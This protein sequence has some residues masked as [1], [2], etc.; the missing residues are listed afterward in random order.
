RFLHSS[1]PRMRSPAKRNES[2]GRRL[3][4]LWD[5]LARRDRVPVG[6]MMRLHS[7]LPDASQVPPPADG[8]VPALVLNVGRL[9]LH[10]RGVG[11]IRSLGRMGVPAYATVENRWPPAAVSRY[12]A[13]AFV[14]DT[15]RLDTARFLAGMQ[16]IGKQ[17]DRPTV[18]IPTGDDAAIL[19]AEHADEL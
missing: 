13:G 2:P 19:I 14:W 4:H 16:L 11:I 10:H 17:L 3:P 8:L 5:R 6:R 7:D 15:R 1:G 18:L 9:V 12:L